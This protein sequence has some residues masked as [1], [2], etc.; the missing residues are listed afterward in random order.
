MNTTTAG[1][2]PQVSNKWGAAVDRRVYGFR[3]TGKWKRSVASS[4][5]LGWPSVAEELL[6]V[7]LDELECA[8]QPF[9]SGAL[10][11]QMA[12]QAPATTLNSPNCMQKYP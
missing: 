9:P 1:A 2:K 12:V 5:Q 4:V 6:S 3:S 10:G 7:A 11:A 8:T